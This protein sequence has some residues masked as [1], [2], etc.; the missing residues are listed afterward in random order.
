MILLLLSF[1]LS[2]IIDLKLKFGH[3]KISTSNLQRTTIQTAICRACYK[4]LNDVYSD[5]NK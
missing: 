3:P 1:K 2:F 5:P 4:D